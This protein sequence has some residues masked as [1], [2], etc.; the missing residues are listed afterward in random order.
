ME[1]TPVSAAT[2][3]SSSDAREQL[4]GERAPG[5]RRARIGAADGPVAARAH[6]GPAAEEAA[7]VLGLGQRALGAR[8]GDLQRV[9]L[10]DG[11]EMVRDPL[12]QVEAH[13][14]GVVDE[15]PH[16]LSAHHL[17][18]QDL[19]VGLDVAKTRL[20]VGLDGAH[21]HL[22]WHEKSGPAPAFSKTRPGQDR[23]SN[24]SKGTAR[25]APRKGR[26]GGGAGAVA[27]DPVVPP[28]GPQAGGE[29]ERLARLAHL[30]ERISERPRQN[31]A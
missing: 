25:S 31:S 9:V 18:E 1:T 21:V 13:P 10:A 7:E 8:R 17:G 14:V 23:E 15:Q 11:R 6:A 26:S 20:D 28:L 30:P 2:V 12:A 22:L 5:A 3:T 19:D 27:V 16:E 24:C 29:H 4:P